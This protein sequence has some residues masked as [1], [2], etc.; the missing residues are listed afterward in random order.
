[1]RGRALGKNFEPRAQCLAPWLS[2]ELRKKIDTTLPERY[3]I[4]RL[5]ERLQKDGITIDEMDEIGAK[6]QKAGRRALSPLV[7]KLWRERSGDLISRYTYL[8]DFFEDETWLDQLVQIALRRRDLDAEGKAAL[9]AALEGYG[10]DV[11]TPP[12]ARLLA[13]IGGPLDVTLPRLLDRGEEGIIGFID[14]LLIYPPETRLAIIRELPSVPDPRVLRLLEI[15][16]RVDDGEVARETVLALGKVR[17]ADAAALLRTADDMPDASL[18]ELAR[19]SLRRLSFLGVEASAWPAA[20]DLPF[21]DCYASPIDGAGYRT[22]WLVRRQENGQ[23]AALCLEI[24]ES[25][26]MTSAWGGGDLADGECSRHVAEVRCEEELFEVEAEYALVL[27]RDACHLSRENG[28]FLPAE[29][30][31]RYGMFRVTEVMPVPYTPEFTTDRRGELAAAGLVAESAALLDDD[32][33]AD[34]VLAGPLVYD[35][36]EE[37]IALETASGGQTRTPGMEPLLERFCREII[38]PEADIIRRRLYLTAD[39]MRHTGRDREAVERTV[40][41]AASLD[42]PLM[43]PWRHPFFRRYAL[44]SM[45]MAREALAGGYDPRRH[46]DDGEDEWE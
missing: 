33:F 21:H 28:V 16:L 14:D 39:L 37:W 45:Q 1:M 29:F 9:L 26:G 4:L 27:L 31:V 2:M 44:E 34:W 13:E 15:L 7:R 40:A 20:R 41:T 12:F 35:Y 19:K 3:G 10:V 24:H 43:K 32:Y 8:L 46:P 5:L 6:L 11:S 23:L 25:R 36:A 42:K 30:Y 18:R 38:V 17:S 22:L